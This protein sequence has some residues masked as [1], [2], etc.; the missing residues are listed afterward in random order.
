MLVF[1]FHF[2][3]DLDKFSNS[4]HRDVDRKMLFSY[5]LNRDGEDILSTGYDNNDTEKTDRGAAAVTEMDDDTVSTT[6][7]DNNVMIKS[8]NE[9]SSKSSSSE[10]GKLMDESVYET[11]KK[12]FPNSPTATPTKRLKPWQLRQIEEDRTEFTMREMEK[13]HIEVLRTPKKSEI[14]QDR[15]VVIQTSEILPLQRVEGVPSNIV[16]NPRA[17]TFAKNALRKHPLFDFLNKNH[18]IYESDFSDQNLNDIASVMLRLSNMDECQELPIF[19]TMASVGDEL[20]WQLIENFVYTMVKFN[21]I[22]CALVICVSDNN[23]MDLCRENLFPCYDYQ[24]PIPTRKQQRDDHLSISPSVM[25]Q[26]AELKLYHIPKAL[27]SGVNIFM[28]D[29]DVGFLNDPRH[30]IKPFYEVPTIDIFVQQDYLF[31]MNRT[32][33]GW[34][35]WFTEPLPNIGLFLCRGNDKTFRVFE[36]AWRKYQLMDDKRAKQNPGKDQNHV[37]DGM[38][39][40]RGTFGLR[41][42][43]FSNST[44]ALMDKIVQHWRGIELGGESA[45]SMLS[46]ENTLAIHTTCYEQSTKVMGLKATNAYWNPRYYD[47]LRPTITKKIIFFSEAQLLDELRSMV[48]LAMATKRALIIPNLFGDNDSLLKISPQYENQAMWPGFRT[49]F[50]KRVRKTNDDI[51]LMQKVDSFTIGNSA[52]DLDVDVSNFKSTGNNIKR[53]AL[54]VQLLE[55]SFYWRVQ[56]DY[57]NVPKPTI[58]WIDKNDDMQTIKKKIEN[59]DSSNGNSNSRIVISYRVDNEEIESRRKNAEYVIDEEELFTIS[60]EPL[61]G[62]EK[63]VIKWAEHS[64]GILQYSFAAEKISYGALPSI[65]PVRKARGVQEVLQ[66]MRNCKDVFG[67][68]RGNRTCFQICD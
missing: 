30:M 58:L 6:I 4:V 35:Q 56:R 36:H 32:K 14:K 28:L 33:A 57:D 64:I 21:L 16:G 43:Y 49:I 25:E 61:E 67:R 5:P 51:F 31:I 34:K 37:L 20:Y 12:A 11:K 27:K 68:L 46:A 9:G 38:R 63:C 50:L 17:Y 60:N 41:Y 40:G 55:P 45:A 29:L 48:W 54:G 47:P 3:L 8:R 7:L 18:S 13:R 62:K 24:R 2:H 59:L 15:R 10:F 26:I 1:I 42:A 39:V 23:C 52:L 65:K 44:A 66:G 22:N 53:N 19:L